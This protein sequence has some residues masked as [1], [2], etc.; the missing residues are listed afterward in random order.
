MWFISLL[1]I[2]TL[3]LNITTHNIST[4]DINML[5]HPFYILLFILCIWA[6]YFVCVPYVC[7]VNP[8]VGAGIQTQI[9]RREASTLN[10]WVISPSL[11]YTF[12]LSYSLSYWHLF[13]IDFF[14]SWTS[15]ICGQLL[16]YSVKGK[17]NE[18]FVCTVRHWCKPLG[19]QAAIV[20]MP[21]SSVTRKT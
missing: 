7:L 11:F 21:D 19:I 14:S 3:T 10:H 4:I 16:L 15:K 2:S 9:S 13:D 12:L 20:H 17:K 5:L 8:T 18:M 1:M 6:F